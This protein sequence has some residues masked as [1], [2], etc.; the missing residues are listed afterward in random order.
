[1][2]ADTDGYI[3]KFDIYQGRFELV[4]KNLKSFGLGE[5]VVLK[6]FDHLHH[7]DHEVYIDNYFTSIPF[8][9]LQTLGVRACGTIKG[10]R[11]YIPTNLQR[12]KT[13]ARG[14]FDYRVAGDISYFK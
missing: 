7:K 2:I 5:R 8:S 11:K 6:L 9:L 14:D 13:M 10:N 3:N 1:M 12:D 4:P